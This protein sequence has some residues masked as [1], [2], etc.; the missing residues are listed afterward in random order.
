MTK[1]LAVKRDD[2]KMK[3][4][5]YIPSIDESSGGVGAYMQLLT[6]DLGK[7]CELHVVSH[8]GENERLLENCTLHYLPYK[9]K[10]WNH[11][12]KDFLQLLDEVKPDVFH[13]NC[14]WMPLSAMTAMWAKKAGYPV[15]YTPHGM[16]EPYSIA[17][18]YWTKKLPAI[19]LFQKKGVRICD[20]VHATA[21][22]EKQNLL[23]LGWNKQVYVVPNC[24]Q[25]DDIRMKAS[26]QRT[27]QLLFLSRVHPK[28]GLN[29]LIE[30]LGQLKTEFAG[31][32]VT[33]AGPGEPAYVSELKA[34]AKQHGVDGLIDF[35]GPV[36][37]KDKWPLYRKADLFVLPTYS[38]N[39]GIVV[40]EAL[41]SG[42][43]VIT[44]H[45]T[46]WEELNTA[47]CGWWTEIGTAPL[48]EALRSFLACDEATLQQM[49]KNG[50]AL[51]EAHYTS[52]AVA[53]QFVEMYNQVLKGKKIAGG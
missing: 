11:C 21:E 37:A 5:H 46:P 31:Y 33:I 8:R 24:V 34:M 26:W 45:G 40:P 43:P 36:Y 14:C 19:L 9:W 42:T 27:K 7:L 16:L 44:T 35:V 18:H 38:E 20:L 30:A 17:R 50:R 39:F 48:V 32:T 4:L 29:F 1:G 6:R 52:E 28:K 12:R 49:G 3:I 2:Y 23:K 41:A 10:P 51:V 22:S 47:H 53:N 25:I 13:V 15:V